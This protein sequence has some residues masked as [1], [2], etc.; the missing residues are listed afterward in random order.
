MATRNVVDVVPARPEHAA[1]LVALMAP[2]D[3]AVF[4]ELGEG[5]PA[6]VIRDGIARSVMTWC[7]REDGAPLCIGGVIPI[8]GVLS[9]EG[10]IW[11]VSQ[12]G[13]ERHKKR[14][15]RE[16][17]AGLARARAMYPVLR[18]F[19]DARY[20]KSLRWLGWLGF[21]IGDETRIGSVVVRPVEIGGI[22][23]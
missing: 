20:P 16:S 8:G 19:V 14:F 11:M 9:D 23:S 15:L 18:N 1:M 2:K 4:A 3:L 7:G 13:L 12:P 22:A 21:S 10:L 5:D 17:R 6:A